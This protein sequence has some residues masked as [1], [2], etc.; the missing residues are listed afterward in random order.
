MVMLKGVAAFGGL[1]S[2]VEVITVGFSAVDAPRVM[3][4]KTSNAETPSSTDSEVASR[5]GVAGDLG[6]SSSLSLS[7]FKFGVAC[8]VDVVCIKSMG[9]ML[10]PW[11][12][13]HDAVLG[14]VGTLR[15]KPVLR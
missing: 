7:L 1:S 4:D 15:A 6:A 3:V 13:R 2:I 11:V 14:L 10:E 8:A 12:M 9:E 5:V